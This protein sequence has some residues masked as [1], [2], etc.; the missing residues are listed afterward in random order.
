MNEVYTAC[1]VYTL[2][3]VVDTTLFSLCF[4]FFI[5]HF[6]VYRISWEDSTWYLNVACC[7]SLPQKKNVP[8]ILLPM[9]SNVWISGCKI[10]NYMSSKK[11]KVCYFKHFETNDIII[12]SILQV[13]MWWCT[14]LSVFNFGA[15]RSLLEFWIFVSLP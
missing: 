12:Y 13:F 10:Y 4:F 9:E 2:C 8:W 5:I 1:T 3:H 14:G 7:L 15:C 11:E 6:T